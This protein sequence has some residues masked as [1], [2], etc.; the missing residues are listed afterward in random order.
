MTSWALNSSSS[1]TRTRSG[2]AARSR[3]GIA[4]GACVGRLDVPEVLSP[5]FITR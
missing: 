4:A 1:A 3:A 2:A 5:R